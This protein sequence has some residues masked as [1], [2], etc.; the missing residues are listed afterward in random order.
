MT[1]GREYFTEVV[2]PLQ[3]MM[4]RVRREAPLG[5]AN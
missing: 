1:I 2:R 5:D 4:E 3:E